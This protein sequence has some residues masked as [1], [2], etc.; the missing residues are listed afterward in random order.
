MLGRMPDIEALAGTGLPGNGYGGVLWVPAPEVVERARVTDY[1]RWLAARGVSVGEPAA[2][3]VGAGGQ[4]VAGDGPA[5]RDYP[6]LWR[7]A[8]DEPGSFLGF[9]LGYLCGLGERG[10]GPGPAGGPGAAGR[11][12]SR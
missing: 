12:V 9:L 7:G 6:R 10:R 11:R 1:R 5:A 8:G 4:A 3:G 2:R